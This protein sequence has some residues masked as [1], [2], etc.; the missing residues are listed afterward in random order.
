M[1]RMQIVRF[2]MLIGLVLANC[3]QENGRVTETASAAQK[4]DRTISVRLLPGPITNQSIEFDL[5]ILNR[6][7]TSLYM[8]NDTRRVD[9]T[10]GP[11]ISADGGDPAILR[12]SLQLFAPPSYNLYANATSAHLRLLGPGA[13][14]VTHFSVPRPIVTTE[15]PY[16]LAKRGKSIPEDALTKAL[17]VVGTLPA[18]KEIQA[19]AYRGSG[20]L[21][22]LESV[23]N[24]ESP[25]DL[26]KLQTLFYSSASPISPHVKE[27]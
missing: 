24:G 21:T 26:Y 25:S 22:G 23:T 18:T 11:Y 20:M 7:Q 6:G 15:P 16:D 17:I 8:L 1:D 19:L 27:R 9:G 5:E 13:K 2:V 4:D 10:K 14:Y 3:P 12:L